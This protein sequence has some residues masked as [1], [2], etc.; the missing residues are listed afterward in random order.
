MSTADWSVVGTWER[1]MA[2]LLGGYR[3]FREGRC[4]EG[5]MSTRLDRGLAQKLQSSLQQC[6]LQQCSFIVSS[7][8]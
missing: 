4:L 2:V 7:Q 8:S 6:N 5:P 3:R 1:C